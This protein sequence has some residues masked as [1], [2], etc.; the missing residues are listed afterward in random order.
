MTIAIIGDIIIDE[1]VYGDSTRL[2]PEAPVA[3]VKHIKTEQRPGGAANVFANVQS[4]MDDVVMSVEC[5]NPPRKVR[6]FSRGHYVTRIDYEGK[7]DWKI[8]DNY[9]DADL[10]II[11]DYDKGCF[12]HLCQIP[13]LNL[14]KT[15]VDVKKELRYYDG[16]WCIKPNKQEFEQYKGSWNSFDELYDIMN[17]AMLEFGF[18]HVIVT[19]G[20]DGVAYGNEDGY[21]ENYP[22][23]AV[24]VA[25][26]TGAGDTF[27]SVLGVALHNGYDMVDAI[28]LANEAAGIA[29]SHLG[30]YVIKSTDIEL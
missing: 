20:A 6:V 27:I 24:E 2:S 22:S 16:A 23:C 13:N 12:N 30:T 25:D 18:A 21:F 10:I 7:H 4:L 11:S 26:V 15:I 5:D 3:V 29:V 1:Y 19:L 8:V 28:K 14:K 17:D 9:Q